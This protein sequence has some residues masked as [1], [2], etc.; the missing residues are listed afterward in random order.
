MTTKTMTVIIPLLLSLSTLAAETTVIKNVLIIDQTIIH[1]P[2]DA[3][4][5]T[6]SKNSPLNLVVTEIGL[7]ENIQRL[8][9]KLGINKV[10]W[11][12][13]PGCINWHID[14]GYSIPHS[15]IADVF[16]YVLRQYPL[17]SSYYTTNKVLEIKKTDHLPGCNNE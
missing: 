9:D 12:D 13:I 8:A 10:I 4:L 6:T 5:Y 17:T 1:R 3:A 15:E 7:R 11:T 16:P 14:A 2:Y